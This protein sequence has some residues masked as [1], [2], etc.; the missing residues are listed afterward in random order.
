MSTS[1]SNSGTS[2]SGLQLPSSLQTQLH[3]FRRRVWKIKSIEAA[4]GAIFGV[5]LAYL[6]VFGLDRLVDTP[7]WARTAVFVLA[8]VVCAMVPVYLH[9]W[10]WCHRRLEQ[11]AHL[12][13]RRYPSLG[14]QMLGIIELVR[15]EFEQNRSRALCEAAI[16]Q[17]AHEAGKRDF[18]DAVP[19]PRHRL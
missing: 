16:A 3:E 17:V 14:D 12:V 8:I 10:I 19:N 2:G 15:N 5:L 4:A 13:S 9:R 18:K 11:L 7:A 6:L 1:T